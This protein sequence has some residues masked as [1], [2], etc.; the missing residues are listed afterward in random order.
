M[1]GSEVNQGHDLYPEIEPHNSGFLPV[2]GDHQ[3]YYEE[4]GN[5]NGEPILFL[6]GGPGGG[7]GPNDRSCFD[8]EKWRIIL[9]DQ[10]GSGRS[11]PFGS[12]ENNNTWYLAGD[13]KT[14]LE[15]LDVKKTVLFGGSWGS[16]L[17]L[18]FSIIFPDMVSG[19]VLRGIFLG[20]KEESDYFFNGSTALFFPE[21]WERFISFVPKEF[22]QDPAK[23]YSM[24]LKSN[25]PLVRKH[26]A[27]EW[28]RYEEALLHLEPQKDEAVDKE[29]SDFPYESLAIMEM[30]YLYDHNCFLTDKHIIGNAR[31]IPKVPISIIQGRYDIVCPPISAYRLAKALPNAELHIVTAG[32]SSSEPAIRQKLIEETNAMF[33]KITK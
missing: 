9:F 20:E 28:A 29:T 5:P 11:R 25:E 4:C 22:K 19:M 26:F 27:Y 30:H 33:E 15:H 18:V 3:L 1:D 31:N 21:A 8:P 12:I 6:H 16:T 2:V 17:A 10:R 32:H 23:Y 7:C 13:I 24:Q 14:L